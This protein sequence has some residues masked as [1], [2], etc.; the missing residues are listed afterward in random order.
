[1]QKFMRSADGVKHQ[2]KM[3]QRAATS[4]RKDRIWHRVYARCLNAK[5]RCTHAENYAGRGIEFRFPS[6]AAMTR[7]ILETLGPPEVGHSLDRIDNDGHYEPGNL[8]WATTAQQNSNKRPYK[9]GVYGERITRLMA[10]TDYGYESI[11]TFIN[12]GMTNDEIITRKRRPGGRPRVR[13]C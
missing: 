9:G 1:M 3:T 2:A 12:E 10:Q 13:H 4:N 11:R 5:Q 8:R 7:W 6:P